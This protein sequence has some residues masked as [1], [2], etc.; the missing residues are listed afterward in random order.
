MSNIGYRRVNPDGSRNVHCPRCREFV[1]TVSGM[2][3][4]NTAICAVC[5]ALDEGIDLSH[6]DVLALR[7]VRTG[8]HVLSHA[9]AYP[10]QIEDPMVAI[11]TD[12]EEAKVGK[13]GY[14]VKAMVS[15]IRKVV[16]KTTEEPES[17]KVAKEKRNKRIFELPIDE[18]KDV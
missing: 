15:S 17:K 3:S 5:H 1:G 10:E 11:A 18:D 2:T 8:G 7:A 12:K 16:N 13:I 6:E 4:I 14:F 9:A